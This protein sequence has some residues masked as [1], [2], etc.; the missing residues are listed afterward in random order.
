[1]DQLFDRLNRIERK[2]NDR[3]EDR[4]HEKTEGFRKDSCVEGD[5]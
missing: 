5:P 1:M 3:Q 2:G 4:R